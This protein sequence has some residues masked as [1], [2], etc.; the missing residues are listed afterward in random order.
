MIINKALVHKG[1]TPLVQMFSDVSKIT[2][3]WSPNVFTGK[4]NDECF[5]IAGKKKK[6]LTWEQ[7][8]TETEVF[9]SFSN[10]LTAKGILVFALNPDASPGSLLLRMNLS[11]VWKFAMPA[12]SWVMSTLSVAV[13]Q[14]PNAKLRTREEGTAGEG[15]RSLTS[16]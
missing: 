7:N 8:Q 14:F 5:K 16:E 6:G 2:M 11:S 3:F 13:A 1:F 12:S 15:F 10:R 9:P 4:S